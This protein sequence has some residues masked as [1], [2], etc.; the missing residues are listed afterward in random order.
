VRHELEPG[1]VIEAVTTV[2][3]VDGVDS[4]SGLLIFGRTHLYMLDGLVESDDGEVIDALDAPKK[5]FFVPGSAVE[6]KGPQR[7]QRWAHEQVSSFS[8][9][10]FLFRDVALEIYFKDS[11]SLLVVF[12][13][14]EAT[15]RNGPATFCVYNL[16][17]SI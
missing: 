3:R 16:S 1:D 8:D 10:T 14:Q 9:R 13:R 5:L 2:A 7:A 4:S 6:L 12:F 15:T 17:W 11:R